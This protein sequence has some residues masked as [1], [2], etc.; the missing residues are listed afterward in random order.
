MGESN[1]GSDGLMT[2]TM[3]SI[4]LM[5]CD[6]HDSINQTVLLISMSSGC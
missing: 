5:C 6:L 2:E 4:C 1:I 3:L